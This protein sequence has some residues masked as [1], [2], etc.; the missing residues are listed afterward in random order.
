MIDLFKS[1]IETFVLIN[2][3]IG[4]IQCCCILTVMT[5]LIK[6]IIATA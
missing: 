3:I 4:G 6:E 1:Q 2:T 5:V